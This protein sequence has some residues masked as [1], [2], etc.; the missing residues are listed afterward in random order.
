M[1]WAQEQQA[2][3]DTAA[4]MIDEAA[5]TIRFNEIVNRVGNDYDARRIAAMIHR[6][7]ISV[8]FD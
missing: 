2:H 8:H 6:A 5:R 3:R 7:V 1:S 4:E